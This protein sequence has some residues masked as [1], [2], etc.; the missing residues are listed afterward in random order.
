M[1]ST[2]LGVAGQDVVAWAADA[3]PHHKVSRSSSYSLY[4][5]RPADG[6]VIPRLL[7][8]Q[9]LADAAAV[10]VTA[11]PDGARV[12]RPVAHALQLGR[13]I[14]ASCST[15]TLKSQD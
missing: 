1:E 6:S 8:P 4:G 3:V 5:C 2:A 11:R 9:L 7:I 13:H 10:A 14:R 15:G 12:V